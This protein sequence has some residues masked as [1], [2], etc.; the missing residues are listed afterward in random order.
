MAKKKNNQTVVNNIE[1]VNLDVDT[2]K[3]AKAIIEAQQKVEEETT[4]ETRRANKFRTRAMS[5]FNGTIYALISI[6]SIYFIYII[7]TDSYSKPEVSLPSCIVFTFLFAFVAIYS[8]LCQQETF[9]DKA[10][11]VHEHFNTNIALVALIIALIA[12]V[13]GVG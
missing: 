2:E 8:F 12:L 1:S 4:K 10:A 9:N 6:I 13:K 11:D 5:F 3:L 7:W